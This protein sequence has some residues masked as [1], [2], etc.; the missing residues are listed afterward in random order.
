MPSI[1]HLGVGNFFRAHGAAYTQ[2][3]TGWDV[4]GVSFRSAA[5]RD[6]LRA[7]GYRYGLLI[8]DAAGANLRQIR[9]LSDMLVA[10]EDQQRVVDAIA[11]DTFDV[12]TLTVTEKGYHLDAAGALDLTAA[13]VQAD[14]AG[15]APT[16]I[17]S[18][19]R[20]LAQRTAPVTFLSCDNL[21]ENGHKLAHAV[22]CF[23]QA[24]G[25][26]IRAHVTFPS[27]MV[28]RITPA[29]TDAVRDEAGD[30]MAVPTETFTEWVIED[31]FAARCQA[32]PGVQWVPPPM[33]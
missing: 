5:V 14:L 7:Q 12:I 6:G 29:T 26:Q 32:W 3:A 11:A 23:A 30:P 31:R 9:C 25:L 10:P 8:K 27:C 18:L 33:R 20:G 2:E 22:Q 16:V 19:A 17:G 21:P 13:A 24:A 1:L 28:D 4:T 15:G